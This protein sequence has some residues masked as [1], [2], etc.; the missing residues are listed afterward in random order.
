MLLFCS[1]TYFFN[2]LRDVGLKPVQFI[3]CNNLFQGL[4]QIPY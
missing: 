2:H 1:E 3:H 4:L